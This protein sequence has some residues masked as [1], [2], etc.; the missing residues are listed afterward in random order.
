MSSLVAA[1]RKNFPSPA[2][3]R[4]A[5]QERPRKNPRLGLKAVAFFAAH[6]P[7]A[8][9]MY[10]V[11]SLGALH[12][13]VVVLGGV[14]WI[15]VGLKP[16]RAAYLCAYIVGSEVLWR[17]T[18]TPVFWEF[19]KYAAIFVCL[20]ALLR[21]SLLKIPILPV[22][23]FALLLPSLMLAVASLGF[24]ESRMLVSFNLSGPLAISIS[25]VYLSQLHLTR[26]QLLRLLLVLVGPICG[27]ATLVLSNI[28]TKNAIVFTNSSNF[29]ISGGFGPNQVSAIL[30]LGALITY[31]Y[32]MSRKLT[33]F[34]KVACIGLI[35]LFT[36][37]SALTFSRN[38]LVLAGGGALVFSILQ[39]RN[40]RDRLKFILVVALLIGGAYYVI[41]PRLNIF[42]SGAIATR[43]EQKST[44]GR[45]VMV[46]ADLRVWWDHPFLGVGPGMA[47]P[48][49]DSVLGLGK[50]IPAHTEFSRMLSEHGMF[51]LISLVLLLAMAVNNF[52]RGGDRQNKSLMLGLLAWSFLYMSAN[53][54]RLMAPAFIYSI[55][56]ASVLS[57]SFFKPRAFQPV[58]NGSWENQRLTSGRSSTVSNR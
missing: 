45:D 43:F 11:P 24:T 55:T 6:V 22:A 19:G 21:H 2:L 33:V 58:F 34:V 13:L 42:T 32:L 10:R 48:Y 30:G 1:E 16:E 14:L 44:T 52:R 36:T 7:L 51:G 31:I 28:L 17:M 35:F 20:F 46:M 26:E 9:V 5:Y 41:F 27:V 4:L 53:A 29:E 57:E 37:L 56:F 3:L 38:G 49:Y 40:N 18:K 12:A 54:M 47:R 8:I 39:F 25:A 50:N 15:G 23:Y